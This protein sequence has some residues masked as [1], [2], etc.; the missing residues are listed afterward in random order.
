MPESLIVAAPEEKVS[1]AARLFARRIKARRGQDANPLAT[2]RF[3][4]ADYIKERLG[5]TPWSGTAEE[6]GQ[7][8]VLDAYALALRQQVERREYELEHLAA[9]QLTCWHP[10]QII[11]NRIRVTS[12]NNVGKS[13]VASGITNHFFDVFT[14]AIAYTMAPGWNQ[15]HDLL[16]KEIKTDRSGKNL[17]GQILDLELRLAHD[18]FAKGRATNNNAETGTERIQGQHGPHMLFVLDEAEGIADFVWDAV[19]SMASGGLV[20]VLMLANPRTRSSRFHKAQRSTDTV[21]FRIS[22][23]W[24]PNVILDREIIPGAIRRDRVDKMLDDW[25]TPTE[26]HSEDDFTFE[27][28]WRPGIFKPNAE[29]MWR[30]LGLP[31]LNMADNTVVPVGRFEA[32]CLREAP[33]EDRRFARIGVDVARFGRDMGTVYLRHKGTIRRVLHLDQ[34][35]TSEYARQ[36]KALA[37]DLKRQGVINLHIR[38][39]GGGGFGGGVLDQL[40]HDDELLEGFVEYLQFEVHNGGIPYDETAYADLVTEMY[41]ESAETLKGIRVESPPDTLEED[42]TERTYDWRNKKGRAVRI[43]TPKDTFR[44]THKRSPDDG[45]GFVLAAAPDYIFFPHGPAMNQPIDWDDDYFS[46]SPY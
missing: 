29:F 19:D 18:H 35:D 27:V 37:M 4:P 41:F 20:I 26:E 1:A 32:A 2:Y 38:I 13:K 31:P 16:W 34:V 30:S 8:Q 6:P 22:Q 9:G 44:E 45:D 25:C 46:I 33:P 17:P 5:W 7:V 24:H 23:T 10:G 21:S 42:L 36:I 14:P 43:L 12:G 28:P 39:D 40:G 11:Q 3:R 15:I